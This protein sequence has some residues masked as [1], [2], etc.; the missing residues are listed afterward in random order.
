MGLYH[1]M[2]PTLFRTP[3]RFSRIVAI[4][5]VTGA[6]VLSGCGPT[7]DDE[8]TTSEATETTLEITGA[9]STP[10]PGATPIDQSSATP[11]SNGE[12]P[13]RGTPEAESGAAVG[14]A[15]PDTTGPMA[16]RTPV[17][18]RL[19]P[20]QPADAEPSAEGEETAPGDG[21][22]GSGPSGDEATSPE[23]A[24]PD[25]DVTDESASVDSCEP[26]EVPEFTGDTDRFIVV[27]NLNFRTGPGVDC[28]PI[29][30]SLLESGTELTVTSDPVIR[31]GEDT[32]WVRVE[33][34]G[35]EGWV[36]V[37][38]IEPQAE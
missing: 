23:D 29:G 16:G 6:L 8:E 32:E 14:D 20:P 7:G 21:T 15:T 5:M 38:F 19:R 34:E 25:A 28:D 12:G 27:A 33:L 31:D 9:S 3:P 10:S 18:G 22:T 13:A 37:E 26:E 24:S 4:C 36:A 35:Q 17:P 1:V 30:D 2:K 11:A